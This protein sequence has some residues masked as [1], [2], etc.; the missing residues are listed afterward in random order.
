[1]ALLHWLES[2]RNPLLDVLL[3]ICSIFGEEGAFLVI[4][5]AAYWCYDKRFG[6]YLLSVGFLGTLGAQF[7]KIFCRI[8]R[9]WVLDPNFT[10]VEAARAGATG[11]S[12][13][14][15]HTMCAACCFGAIARETRS[16]RLRALCLIAVV[17]TALSRMYLGVHTPLDVGVSLL[18]AAVLVFALYPLRRADDRVFFCFFLSFLALAAA[19]LLYTLLAAFPADVDK[20]NLTE[21]VKNGWSLTGAVLGMLAAFVMDMHWLHFET[22]A[23]RKVQILK[24]L[25]GLVLALCLKEGLKPLLEL[26]FGAALF[27]NAI[28][29]FL[30]VLFAGAV[31]PSCFRMFNKIG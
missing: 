6:Y 1:M 13:P 28:R 12:F 21:A 24:T 10:I 29:Y 25:L 31:W 27:S 30:V 4:G 9:P 18:I 11:Y 14:S 17:L 20:Q 7:L 26:L 3:F 5:L 2:I 19:Y 23:S 22:H 8:P 15:G 16:R